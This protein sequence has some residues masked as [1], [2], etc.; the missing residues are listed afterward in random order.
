MAK[1]AAVLNMQGGSLGR[2]P[3]ACVDCGEGA[4]IEVEIDRRQAIAHAGQR[5]VQ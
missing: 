2:A 3:V 1:Q 4:A 5:R